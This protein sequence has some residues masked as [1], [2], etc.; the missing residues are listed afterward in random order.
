[1]TFRQLGSLAT[2]IA[3]AGILLPAAAFAVG[4]TGEFTTAG[5]V[6]ASGAPQYSNTDALYTTAD[7]G[8]NF[9]LKRFFGSDYKVINARTE[10]ESRPWEAKAAPSSARPDSLIVSCNQ[11]HGKKRGGIVAWAKSHPYLVAGGVAAAVAIPLVLS[12]DEADR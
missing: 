2:A 12:E 5:Y 11:S 3:C 4:P 6:Q 10:I 9:T 8:N 1:M 7:P